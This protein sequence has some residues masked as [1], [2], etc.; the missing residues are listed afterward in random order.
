MALI[1]VRE[2][3]KTYTKGDSVIEP[4]KNVS[5]DIEQGELISLMGASGTGKSTLL[6]LIAGIDAPDSGE[7]SVAGTVITGLSTSRL[8]RWRADNIGYIFQTH[9]LIPVLTAYENI[10]LPLLLLPISKPER[11]RRVEIALE[12]VGLTDRADHFPR[13]MS[14]GQ[15]QRVGIGRAIVTNPLVI[16]AD[17]PTGDLDGETSDQILNLLYNLNQQLGTTL[18]MVTHDADATRIA[19]RRLRLVQGQIEEQQLIG[20]MNDG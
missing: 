14:G 10:E 13:Q 5:L 9:N 4:L 2:L 16:V 8:T 3:T 18:L 11:Q 20:A 19:S 17:E 15:E 7:I 6:N 1:E 12:A